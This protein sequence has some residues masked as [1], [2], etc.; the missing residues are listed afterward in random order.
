MGAD[1]VCC[2]R[3]HC[4]VRLREDPKSAGNARWK[5][6]FTGELKWMQAEH[7]KKK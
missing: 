6:N 3:L 4:A 5:K 2:W 1:F 7:D